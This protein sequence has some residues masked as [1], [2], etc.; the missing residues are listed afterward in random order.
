ML[1]RRP[2]AIRWQQRHR[3]DL[4]DR[5]SWWR[6]WVGLVAEVTGQGVV[7]RRLRVLSEPLSDYV[8]EYD[9]TLTNVEAGEDMRWLP[10]SRAP[11]LLWP[12]SD[13]WVL[14][15]E[16]VILHHFSG[17]GQWTRPRM[18]VCHDPALVAQYVKACEAA[19]ERDSP[20][21][22]TNPPEVTHHGRF[23]VIPCPT[24]PA[25]SRIPPH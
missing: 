17:E 13:G 22:S 6:P 5:D 12:A 3:Y 20:T 18:E 10:R 24:S 11:D 25:G 23:S 14:D 15:E 1:A 9:G 21:R 2:R 4:A 16:T 19:W 7:T 8:R